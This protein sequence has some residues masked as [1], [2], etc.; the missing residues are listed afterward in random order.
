MMPSFSAA[1]GVAEA[2]HNTMAKRTA[3]F[4]KENAS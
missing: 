3:N 1:N 4:F 2:R